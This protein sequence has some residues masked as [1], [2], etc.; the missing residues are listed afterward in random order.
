MCLTVLA[1][2][3]RANHGPLG[4]CW[5]E[6][7]STCPSLMKEATLFTSLCECYATSVVLD[8][9]TLCTIAHQAPLSMGF[10]RQ[11]YWSGL[12]C[13]PLGIF[14]IQGLNL[15]L[16]WLLGCR[17]IFYHQAT[18]GSLPPLYSGELVL[19]RTEAHKYITEFHW[20]KHIFK[21]SVEKQ[22]KMT[23]ICLGSTHFQIGLL[24]KDG[25]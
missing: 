20:Y 24:G 11:E 2:F 8:S 4:Q 19:L 21:R 5:E 22:K 14:L 13:L 6:L 9:A 23:R 17:R 7:H 3:Q 15:C 25:V 10:S 1:T 18:R 12:P 16:L